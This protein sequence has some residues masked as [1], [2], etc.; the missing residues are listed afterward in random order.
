MTRQSLS[1]YRPPSSWE[2]GSIYS[3]FFWFLLGKPLLASFIPGTYWRK[4]LLKLFGARIGSGGRLKPRLHITDPRM[5]VV[6]NDCWFGEDLWIDNLAPVT[7]GDEVCLSQGAYLCTG[8]HNY[9]NHTFE[10]RLGPITIEDCAWIAAKSI[11][12]P[13][14]SIGEGSVV[15]IGSVVSG[16][17]PA[18]L[19]VK[20]NPAVEVAKRW[21]SETTN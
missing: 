14:T 5:L 21:K 15:S 2:R 19:I 9:R 16:H 20:G 4:S 17:I 6:G 7:I 13:G 10:L 12:S 3:R 18:G 11:L 1:S 8:N